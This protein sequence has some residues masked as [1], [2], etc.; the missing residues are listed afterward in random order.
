MTRLH[1][2]IGWALLAAALLFGMRGTDVQAQGSGVQAQPGTEYYVAFMQNEDSRAAQKFMGMMITSQVSTSV[3]VEIP[4]TPLQRFFV[5]PGGFITVEVPRAREMVFSEEAPM[6][7]VHVSA[8]A[9]ISVFAVNARYQSSGGYA[10][11]P[12]ELWRT[13]YLPMT[14]PNADGDRVSEFMVIASEDNTIVRITPKARTINSDVGQEIPV[15]LNRGESFLVQ[16]HSGDAGVADLSVSEIHANRPIGVVSGHVGAPVTA[17]GTMP[18]DQWAT[19]LSTMLLP[20]SLWGQE[21]YT[22]PLNPGTPDRFRMTSAFDGTRV[23]ITCFAPDGSTQKAT[24]NLDRGTM[25]DASTIGGKP[26]NGPVHWSATAPVILTQ[27]RTSGAY[28]DAANAPMML[29]VAPAARMTTFSPFVAPDM[30][31]INPLSAHMLTLVAKGN[32]AL[33]ASDNANPIQAITLDGHPLAGAAWQHLNGDYFYTRVAVPAGGHVLSSPD[34]YPFTGVIAGNSGLLGDFYAF[35][36]PFWVPRIDADV[37]A[38]YLVTTV[39]TADRTRLT[40]RISDSTVGYYSGIAAV[41]VVQSPGWKLSAPFQ[42]PSPDAVADVTFQTTADPSGPLFAALSDRSGNIDTV[43]LSDGICLK[44]AYT[45]RSAIVIQT[46]YG[47]AK[48]DSLVIRA[49]DCGSSATISRFDAGTGNAKKYIRTSFD[50]GLPYAIASHGQIALTIDVDAA[51]DVGIYTTTLT[52]VADSTP[53]TVPLR[54]EVA[55]A[56]GVAFDEGASQLKISIV[57]NP[58]SGVMQ[59]GFA[60]PLGRDAQMVIT[61]PVGHTVARMNG[62]SLAGRTSVEWSGADGSGMLLPSGVYFVVLTDG[63][64]RSVRSATLVR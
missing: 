36:L 2:R 40:A 26:I 5:Q 47:T 61:D 17:N 57:P 15:P 64:N 56:A 31:G 52:I 43:K 22:V 25:F 23:E 18:L 60:R 19:H 10:A 16:A 42:A 34:G 6:Q 24:V 28:G 37:H 33:Q 62:E 32:G 39:P 51:A 53:I 20:D 11:M 7:T 44:T 46:T 29:P 13:G 63:G 3:D 4:G 45:D 8:R 58:S 14:L 41:E 38:P 9:P 49:N 50:S 59:I 21:Y 12:V 30:I 1:H 48:R 55:P 35:P 27:L 54:I